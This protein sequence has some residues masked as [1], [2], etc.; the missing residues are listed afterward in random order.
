MF[1]FVRPGMDPAIEPMEAQ[2]VPDIPVGRAWQYEPKW[3]G[4]RGVVA[5]IDE[6]G[7]ATPAPSELI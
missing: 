3:H 5:S 7:A 2:S 6:W 1:S 4:F